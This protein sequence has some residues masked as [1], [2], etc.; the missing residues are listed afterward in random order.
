MA[1]VLSR[2][3]LPSFSQDVSKGSL[4]ISI[5]LG[6]S[7]FVSAHQK[8]NEDF[9]HSITFPCS[10][11]GMHPVSYKYAHNNTFYPNLKWQCTD[12]KSIEQLSR[13]GPL[14]II[15]YNLM[16]KGAQ[17]TLSSTLSRCHRT[18]MNHMQLPHQPGSIDEKYSKEITEAP[19][20]FFCDRCEQKFSSLSFL[21][22]PSYHPCTD[23]LQGTIHVFAE[24]QRPLFSI[25]VPAC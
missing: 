20:D 18:P 19:P 13:K 10:V 3:L 8:K 1:A 12:H 21:S 2:S 25:S 22:I 24:E 14:K 17:M 7:I 4:D 9:S 5:N 6:K 11:S 15:R 23:L 16:G